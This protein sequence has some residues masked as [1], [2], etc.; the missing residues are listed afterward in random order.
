MR[1][2][3][4]GTAAGGGVPQWNCNC[5]ICREA[6]AGKGRVRPRTQ[7][8]VAISAD[9]EAW[10]LLNASPDIRSQIETTPALRS[11]TKQ[12][13]GSPIEAV[14][15]TNADLD[16]T[17]GLLLMREGKS[18]FVHG[19]QAVRRS[20][21]EGLSLAPVLDS[22]CRME[23]IE[24]REQISP[25]LTRDGR[26][27]GLLCQAIP[28]VGGP[29][30]FARSATTEEGS[31]GAHGQEHFS[32]D[33]IGYRIVDEK[34]GG[35]LLFLPDVA[36]LDETVLSQLSACEA[37]LFDGTFWSE[38]EMLER[39][40]GSEP[41]SGMGHVPISG[42]EGSLKALAELK[43]KHKVYVHINNTNPILFE[44]SPERETVTKAGCQVGMDGI[45][46]SI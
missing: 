44:D 14:L 43:L 32:G 2:V 17:L 23:W 11:H 25:L 10:F 21:T 45:E 39:G 29:P 26:R 38:N 3:L 27:T 24:P 35:R 34:T 15:L 4:L 30:R 13:R 1:I 31:K 28:L 6:R 20:L 41:A 42:E 19:T 9:G 36:V 7:S 40:V 12:L 22:F 5:A 8:S 46:I 18:L 33:V 37:L 16:H